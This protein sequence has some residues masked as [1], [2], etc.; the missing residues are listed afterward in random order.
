[1]LVSPPLQL[2][3]CTPSTSAWNRVVPPTEARALGADFVERAGSPVPP[4]PPVVVPPIPWFT[5]S[6]DSGRM[7]VQAP[8]TLEATEQLRCWALGLRD[9][10]TD[11][12]EVNRS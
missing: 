9:G 7:G 6:S 1:M 5:T 3:A 10:F 11:T 8:S 2:G 4:R 12:Y